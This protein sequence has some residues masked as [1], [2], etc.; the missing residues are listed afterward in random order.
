MEK[1]PVPAC[2]VCMTEAH[3]IFTKSF[4]DE[5]F[6]HNVISAFASHYFASPETFPWC[7]VQ[8]ILRAER[9]HVLRLVCIKALLRILE[10]A[11]RP[12]N[13]HGKTSVAGVAAGAGIQDERAVAVTIA[14]NVGLEIIRSSG[15]SVID[16]DHEHAI[17][18]IEQLAGDKDAC[19]ML[20]ANG[21]FPTACVMT[22]RK[23]CPHDSKA[24]HIIRRYAKK[25]D[26][27]GR[28]V[29]ETGGVNKDSWSHVNL[30]KWKL[31]SL[32]NLAAGPR[33]LVH[34]MAHGLSLLTK[35]MLCSSDM[36]TR[37][38]ALCALNVLVKQGNA[39]EEEVTIP[40]HEFRTDTAKQVLTDSRT[41]A[42]YLNKFGQDAIHRFVVK[43]QQD[44]LVKCFQDYSRP[45]FIYTTHSEEAYHANVSEMEA[46]EAEAAFAEVAHHLTDEYPYTL[47][48]PFIKQLPLLIRVA[49]M[50]NEQ[51][52]SGFCLF[53]ACNGATSQLPHIANELLW[54]QKKKKIDCGEI[55]GII[56]G[57]LTKHMNEC[58]QDV[59]LTM[60]VSDQVLIQLG[61]R[62]DKAM[63]SSRWGKLR[64][65][66]SDVNMAKNMLW[67]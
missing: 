9:S 39:A 14:R 43:Q 37:H 4:S 53:L 51:L 47:P 12:A 44:S 29:A 24:D 34:P 45:G 32:C 63:A 19:Y 13:R 2:L 6:G 66:M 26:I 36:F 40:S 41:R 55:T 65:K 11:R 67:T 50:C 33:Q 18:L 20:V 22:E 8:A 31:L 35:S 30:H 60:E 57:K 27:M 54:V 7:S 48:R 58:I 59:P 61:V 38:L 5:A 17:K 23:V 46:G 25:F 3:R 62:F 10:K 56:I 15:R 21:G 49:N 16:G 42:T 64:S 1:P 28:L 52:F